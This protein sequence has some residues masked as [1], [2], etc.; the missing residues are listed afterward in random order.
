M[1][2]K[3]NQDR[4][5]WKKATTEPERTYVNRRRQTITGRVGRYL[6]KD[7]ALQAEKEQP[8]C[9][10]WPAPA[11][12]WDPFPDDSESPESRKPTKEGVGSD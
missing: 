7:E 5:Y 6:T 2:Q 1:S 11:I 10:V 3:Q 4:R 8:G 9:I 12:P